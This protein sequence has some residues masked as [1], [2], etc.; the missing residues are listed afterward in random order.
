VTAERI[1]HLVAVL[2]AGAF[3]A[4]A[5]MSLSQAQTSGDPSAPAGIYSEAQAIRGQAVYNERCWS[6]HGESLAGLDQAPPLVGP[7]FASVWQGE[8][9]A[10]LVARIGTM[11]PDKPGSLTRPESVDVLSY[12]LWY[13]GM[14][15]GEQEL[16]VEQSVLTTLKFES[17]LLAGQ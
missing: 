9:L 12:I 10:A 3:V 4:G 2:A 11:P 1:K 14:P 16:G 6:C 7:Q 8:P 5:S 15:L 17:P 13:N